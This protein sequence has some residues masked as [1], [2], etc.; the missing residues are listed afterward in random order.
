MGIC[1]SLICRYMKVDIHWEQGRAVSFPEIHESGL[2]CSVVISDPVCH[3]DNTYDMLS[4][5]IGVCI[6][7]ECNVLREIRLIITN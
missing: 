7:L 3:M 1:K 2:L 6:E 5:M 4:C